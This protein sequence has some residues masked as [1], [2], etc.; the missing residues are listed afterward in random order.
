VA[1]VSALTET[2]TPATASFQDWQSAQLVT[3]QA[4]LHQATGR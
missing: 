3:L 4:A 1:G 2:L